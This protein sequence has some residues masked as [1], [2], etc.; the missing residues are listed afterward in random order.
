VS[1]TDALRPRLLIVA[2][3]NG[4]GLDYQWFHGCEYDNSI[5][6]RTAQLVLRA[7]TGTVAR[8]YTHTR[9][10]MAPIVVELSQPPAA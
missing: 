8:Q 7:S 1:L 9:A 3:P 10:W 5:D 6:D 2:G 4:A